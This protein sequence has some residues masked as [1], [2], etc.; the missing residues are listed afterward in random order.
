ME[1]DGGSAAQEESGDPADGCAYSELA[2][3]VYAGSVLSIV[4]GED[5]G[6]TNYLC[7]LVYNEGESRNKPT[8]NV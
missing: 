1:E 7:G 8:Q 2:P 5:C 6:S 3:N 4:D